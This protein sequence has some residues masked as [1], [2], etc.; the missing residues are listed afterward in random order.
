MGWAKHDKNDDYLFVGGILLGV[1]QTVKD[2]KPMIKPAI[3][4]KVSEFIEMGYEKATS[5]DIWL[6]LEQRVWK[7][8]PTKKLHEVVQ[9]VFHLS[10]DIYMGYLTMNAYQDDDDL[11]ASIAALTDLY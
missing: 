4:S 6:C 2:W 7:G 8:N 9:D 10:A 5:E 11:M 3:E 1:G